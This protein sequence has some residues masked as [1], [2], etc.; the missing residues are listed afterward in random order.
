MQTKQAAK[1]LVVDDNETNIEIIT[2]ILLG[3]GYEVAVAYDGEYALELAEA[4]DFDLI[5]L[6]ILLPGLSGLDVA[7]RLL[8]TD[9][10][11]NTPILFLSAL[12]E[13]SDIVKGLETGAV[14]YITKP[15]QESEILARIRTHIKIKTLEKERI[16]LLQAIQKDLELAKS[17]QENLVTF[18]FPP[19]P[20]YQIYTSYKPMELVGGDLITYDLLPSGDLD[21]LFGDVTGHGIAAAMVSLMAIITFKTMDKSFLSPSESLF[22]IHNT[23]TPLISTHFISAIYLRYK[24]EENLLSYSMAGH[25]N[26]FLLRDKNII[27]LGTKGFCLMMFPDQLNTENEDIF[28]KAGDRLFLFSDGM[29]EVPND[30][31]EYLGDQKFQTL[32]ESR[33]HLSSQEFLE[34][35]QKEVLSFSGGKVADDMTMLLLE[36]K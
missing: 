34:S 22:W 5:L 24:A 35:V 10:S 14:D 26:M 23:L 19:S 9:R 15:F 4:L 13:T 20:L 32:I 12:N 3:Q 21:I 17:N 18:Q 29:F 2:H 1:I 31:E 25:H 36:I 28:L 7:K 6:D 33:I 30:K 8:A 16:D 11:K 27:K